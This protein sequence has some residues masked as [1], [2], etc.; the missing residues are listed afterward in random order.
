[1]KNLKRFVA[2]FTIIFSAVYFSSAEGKTN[3]C[4][5]GR[6]NF[7]T[8]LGTSISSDTKN[9][10]FDTVDLQKSSIF[11]ITVFEK[12]Q[13]VKNFAVQA[14]TG[15][16]YIKTGLKGDEKKGTSSLNIANF[17]VLALYDFNLNEKITYS[18]LIG[19]QVGY[20]FG[21]AINSGDLGNNAKIKDKMI[22]DFVAGSEF[23]YKLGTGSLIADIRYNCGLFPITNKEQN[24][25][26]YTPRSLVVGVGYKVKL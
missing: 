13:V 25:H 8:S 1:M 24:L 16:N 19:G 6:A 17:T 15:F 7:G 20:I 23:A 21:K 12:I 2:V 5:G 26:L 3:I 18:P 14:E 22:Y 11:G 4:I 10:G 9:A